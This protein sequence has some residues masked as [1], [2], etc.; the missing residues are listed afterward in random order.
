[1]HAHPDHKEAA[2]PLVHSSLK[3]RTGRY[4]KNN[5]QR[6]RTTGRYFKKIDER[7]AVQVV[8]SKK[9]GNGFALK[10]GI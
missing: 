9:F 6:L 10:V 8:I 4:F 1:M 2:Q 7:F 3:D 5:W